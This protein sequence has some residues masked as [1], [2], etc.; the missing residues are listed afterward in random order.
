ML[1][2]SIQDTDTIHARV[3]LTSAILFF[4]EHYSEPSDAA[5]AHGDKMLATALEETGV[6]FD[7]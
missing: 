5:R 2:T 6:L 3:F 1:S 7:C 4:A